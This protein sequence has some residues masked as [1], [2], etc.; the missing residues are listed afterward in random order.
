M[1]SLTHQGGTTFPLGQRPRDDIS[2]DQ[3]LNVIRNLRLAFRIIRDYSR[4]VERQCGV[5]ATQLW[6]LK[7]IASQPGIR[8]SNLSQ[9]LSLHQST[10]SNL[11]DKLEARGLIKR[12]RGG[13][14]QREVRISLTDPGQQLLE[15]APGPREGLLHDALSRMPAPAL[16]ELDRG[17]AALLQQTPFSALAE[18]RA[19]P[20]RSSNC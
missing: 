16:H 19:E 7:E 13:S 8:T 10:T 18:P 17:L 3:L 5:S 15:R 20:E 14:D 11:L 4:W 12:Q 6:T 2:G 9:A 1:A